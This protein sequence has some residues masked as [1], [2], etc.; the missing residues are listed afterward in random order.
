MSYEMKQC[1]KC[2]RLISPALAE[3]SWGS[4]SN[5]TT[6]EVVYRCGFCALKDRYDGHITQRTF[7]GGTT[8]R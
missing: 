3:V 5:T 2:G 8:N 1:P 7:T 6:Y 4:T